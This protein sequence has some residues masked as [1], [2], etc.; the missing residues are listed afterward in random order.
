MKKRKNPNNE[1]LGTLISACILSIIL[2]S[3]A[4]LLN[5][6]K[7]EKFVQT[8]LTPL[9]TTQIQQT[10][11]TQSFK[12]RFR[13]FNNQFFETIENL[14]IDPKKIPTWVA[15]IP[16]TERLGT[17]ELTNFGEEIRLETDVDIPCQITTFAGHDYD[18]YK[19]IKETVKTEHFLICYATKVGN[20][21][22]VPL[23]DVD[24]KDGIPDYINW[25]AEEAE[26]AWKLQVDGKGFTPPGTTV[27]GLLEIQL[28]AC[29]SCSGAYHNNPPKI[30]LDVEETEEYL[31][32]VIQHEFYHALQDS[33][34]D[35]GILALAPSHETDANYVGIDLG[36]LDS[37]SWGKK[38]IRW[39]FIQPRFEEP[40]R[41]LGDTKM[42]YGSYIFLKFLEEFTDLGGNLIPRLRQMKQEGNTDIITI[43][44]NLM[45]EKNPSMTWEQGLSEYHVWNLLS[46]PYSLLPSNYNGGYSNAEDL[47][48]T[49]GS[50]KI[51]ESHSALPVT[52]TLKEIYGTG[53]R[54]VFFNVANYDAANKN[55]HATLENL[56]DQSYEGVSDALKTAVSAVTISE[57]WKV[58]VKYI[59]SF[60]NSLTFDIPKVE[61]LNFIILVIA[62]ADKED[63]YSLTSRTTVSYTAS[64]Q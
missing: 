2:I 22:R 26:K 4:Y 15:D 20:E 18:A 9:K 12:T 64:I 11:V 53:A 3:G 50:V 28:S 29:G 54:Y 52:N 17:L 63:G 6:E 59:G 45:K 38:A 7:I 49:Y 46:G 44:E 25:I 13:N 36:E 8:N 61:D 32:A 35:T 5:R 58:D 40:E 19:D 16:K 62:N 57:D 31:R 42:D 60:E 48:S 55:F 1:H 30:F 10:R 23:T 21:H 24:P 27:S 34:V 43:Y 14:K 47:W 51:E 39:T 41:H 56:D 33:A 37:S